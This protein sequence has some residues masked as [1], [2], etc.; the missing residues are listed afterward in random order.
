[1]TKSKMCFKTSL[2]NWFDISG[3]NMCLE[4]NGTCAF[5]L[6]QSK[7]KNNIIKAFH[8][9][10]LN[11]NGMED[12]EVRCTH[13]HTHKHTHTDTLSSTHTHTHTHTHICTYTHTHTHTA[14][15]NK[16]KTDNKESSCIL[17]CDC[18]GFQFCS[19]NNAMQY[20][21]HQ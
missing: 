21:D 4:V 12:E 16:S 14:N 19:Q 15:K 11:D 18:N 1:M 7:S 8:A 3:N 9:Y 20:Y 6:F 2:I 5:Y 13:T 10:I 17:L